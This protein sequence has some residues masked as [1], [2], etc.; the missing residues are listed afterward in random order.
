MVNI[1]AFKFE[2]RHLSERKAQAL[3]TRAQFLCLLF[4]V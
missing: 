4:Y 1:C 3:T 2:A